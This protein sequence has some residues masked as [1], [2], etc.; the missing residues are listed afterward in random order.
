MARYADRLARPLAFYGILEIGISLYA[1]IFPLL[2]SVLKPAYLSIWRAMEPGP[3]TFGLI[4]FLLV[5][6]ALLLPTAAMGATLPLL[7]RFATRRLGAAGSRIGTLYAV[8]TF[9]AVAGTWFCGFLLLPR[10]GRFST[11]I[12]AAS[13]TS[14]LVWLPRFWI[15]GR[16]EAIQARSRS[17]MTRASTPLTPAL[18]VVSI[19][20]ALA[21]F[22]A[23]I[24]EV[25]WARL[26][27]LMLG[28]S[29]YIF[30]VMLLAFLIG[31]GLGS[32]LG[33]SLADRL[34]QSRRA[35]RGTLR[36]RGN[37]N[38]HCARVLRDDVSLSRTAL[39]VGLA[40]RLGRRRR[41][42]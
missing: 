11:T 42:T 12:I 1:L 13:A 36:I 17:R 31:I 7:A 28:G 4:Q 32:K 8:N 10:A 37:R 34:L 5:A 23:L 29:T 21:G 20:I 24:Y 41:A 6:I 39:L 25:T 2:V 26:L 14:F 35:G 27:G 9:G 33:G 3:L 38:W 40:L 16:T 19:A 30:S 15:A 22:A 18:V